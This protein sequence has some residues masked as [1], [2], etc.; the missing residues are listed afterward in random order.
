[1]NRICSK[2]K[3]EK[4]IEKFYIVSG[5]F[6]RQCKK[7][8]IEQAGKYRIKNK[9]GINARNKKWRKKN[10]NKIKKYRQNYKEKYPNY[11][12]EYQKKIKGTGKRKERSRRYYL[13]HK[14]RIMKCVIRYRKERLKKDIAFKILSNLR[15]RLYKAI[16]GNLKS[17]KTLYLL[18][19]S[20][21][22][23]KYY[24]ESQFQTGMT[25]YNYASYWEIDHIIPCSKFDFSDAEQ[26]NKCFHYSNLQPLT[27]EEN[28]K[29]GN[30]IIKEIT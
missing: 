13:K 19:C 20:S 16:K 11:S 18:G 14:K 27:I 8:K 5:Y 4:F 15:S 3:E 22:V 30:R 24:I 2:C 6:S 7:C 26:Q 25:W 1:M 10:P 17:K 9:D 12:K 28:R 29:K 23:L 21:E